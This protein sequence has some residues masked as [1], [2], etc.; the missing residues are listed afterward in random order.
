MYKKKINYKCNLYIKCTYNNIIITLTN[1]I[2]EV[3]LWSS[4]GKMKFKGSKKTS[5]YAAEIT[6]K[7]IINRAIKLGL[8]KINIFIKGIGFNKDIIIRTIY[9]MNIKISFIKDI[10]PISHNGC[11]PPKKRR[12]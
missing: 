7:D 9:N 8:K 1:K 6:C 2:G 5:S 12:I 11:R 4:S 3:L 10:T